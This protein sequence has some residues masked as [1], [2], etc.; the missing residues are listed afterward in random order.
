[1][2]QL[3]P[4]PLDAINDQEL[5]DLIGEA[6]ALGVPG[7][8]FARI[9]A[10]AP[11]HAKA[12]LRALI[13]SHAEG[14]VDHKLKEVIR[15]QLARFAEDPYFTGLRSSKARAMELSEEVIDAGSA[16]YEDSSFFSEA[17]KCALRYADQMFL[18]ANKVDAELYAELKTHFSEA[19][20]MELGSF[21]ALHYGMQMF[22][23]TLG[24]AAQPPQ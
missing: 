22:M 10:R 4:L 18:D 11:E 15:I 23:R 5:R 17:E 21:I 13:M 9:I 6:E 7:S 2:V 24:N 12:F 8:Q 16:D 3:E 20:I 19:Q 14:N 1:M